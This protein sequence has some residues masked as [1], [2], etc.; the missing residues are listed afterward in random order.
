MA[1][2]LLSLVAVRMFLQMKE[3]SMWRCAEDK[4]GLL[5]ISP[6]EN[7]TTAGKWLPWQLWGDSF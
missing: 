2:V 4:V 5:L 3:K 1:D 7:G 6:G